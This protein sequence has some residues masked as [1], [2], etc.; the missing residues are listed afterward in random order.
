MF[1]WPFRQLGG[2]LYARHLATLRA[3]PLW[4]KVCPTN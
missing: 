3:N 1:A 4:V 2:V